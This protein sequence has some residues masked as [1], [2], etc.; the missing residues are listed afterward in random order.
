MRSG[1]FGLVLEQS[2][3]PDASD[4]HLIAKRCSWMFSLASLYPSPNPTN[5]QQPISEPIFPASAQSIAILDGDGRLPASSPIHLALTHL[6]HED[7]LAEGK[8]DAV[9]A[10][11]RENRRVLILT[12]EPGEWASSFLRDGEDWM[13]THGGRSGVLKRLDRIDIKSVRFSFA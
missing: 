11:E 4:R 3:S 8:Q 2:S 12:R 7:K 1:R 13:R 5:Q 6:A 10:G 9:E